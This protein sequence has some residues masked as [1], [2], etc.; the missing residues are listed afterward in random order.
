[1]SDLKYTACLFCYNQTDRIKKT[2]EAWN[3]LDTPPERIVVMDDGSDDGCIVD[4]LPDNVI[5][6]RFEHCGKIGVLKNYTV[7]NLIETEKFIIGEVSVVPYPKTM[8]FLLKNC[9]P[10]V[11]FSGMVIDV[12]SINYPKIRIPIFN[13]NVNNMWVA[14][15]TIYHKSTFPYGNETYMGAGCE[16]NDTIFRFLVGGGRVVFSTAI[17]F[18]HIKHKQEGDWYKYIPIN[19]KKL[20]KLV[21]FYLENKISIIKKNE[22]GERIILP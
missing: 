22:N 7:D 15:L 16:D 4:E 6:H 11:I 10:E 19:Q 17:Q 18:I 21:R 14:D 1:M 9:T 13:I 20:V 5:I 2:C 8:E 3:S 12:D